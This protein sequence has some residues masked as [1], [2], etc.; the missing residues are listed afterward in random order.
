MPKLF[1]LKHWQ[2]ILL[3]YGPAMAFAVGFWVIQ[4][5][6]LIATLQ[7]LRGFWI[8]TGLVIW[9]WEV[10]H[11]LSRRSRKI[12]VWELPL[13][14]VSLL[15]MVFIECLDLIT[16]LQ[17]FFSPSSLHK[18]PLDGLSD[19]FLLLLLLAIFYRAYFIT[20]YLKNQP[21]DQRYTGPLAPVFVAL[22]LSPIGII[23][24]QP[25]L[26]HLALRHGSKTV[27]L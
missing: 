5:K 19:R 4:D 2:I 13:F 15:A 3:I 12:K 22:L 10:G 27:G 6:I 21:L 17:Q 20:R 7:F 14:K 25:Q 8:Q 16:L 26:N 24:L 23:V 9:F 11:F 1:Y 18:I